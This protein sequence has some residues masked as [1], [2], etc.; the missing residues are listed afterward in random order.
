[1]KCYYLT[2]VRYKYTYTIAHRIGMNIFGKNIYP[3]INN[4]IMLKY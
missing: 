3:K 4:Q 1:M 2:F